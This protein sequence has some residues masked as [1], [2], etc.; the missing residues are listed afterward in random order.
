MASEFRDFRFLI[1]ILIVIWILWFITGGVQRVK[2]QGTAAFITPR[3]DIDD[4]SIVYGPTVGGPE[5]TLEAA[6]YPPGWIRYDTFYFS[7]YMPSDFSYN[8]LSGV[9]TFSGELT[10]GSVTYTFDFGT[11]VEK[12]I[13]DT[14]TKY[15]FADGEIDGFDTTYVKPASIYG[16][17][18]EVFIDRGA[19]ENLLLYGNN[20][21]E[22]NQNILFDIARTVDFR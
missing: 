12:T 15:I 9:N 3:Q 6:S 22:T 14:D 16:T 20:L 2:E 13:K 5:T 21:T 11:L 19:R 7:F 1:L 4:E 18:T 10:N 8:E 17:R